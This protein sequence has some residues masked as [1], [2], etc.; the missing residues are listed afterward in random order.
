MKFRQRFF[1]ALA[2]LTIF[3]A[4]AWMS[5]Y[6]EGVD[7]IKADGS[8]SRTSTEQK[9]YELSADIGEGIG[10]GMIICITTP[11]FFLFVILAWRNGAGYDKNKKHAEM[12]NAVG[13]HHQALPSEG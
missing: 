12:L 13:N 1:W 4:L 11:V 6:S 2:A 5:G 8:D 9:A 10:T 7:E 3:F